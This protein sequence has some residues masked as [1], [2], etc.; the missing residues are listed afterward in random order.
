M[1]FGLI[2]K[3]I[4]ETWLVTLLLGLLIFL[5]HAVMAYAL[6]KF[7]EHFTD[8]I[9][10]LPF[11]REFIQALLGAEVGDD[12]GAELFVVLPWVHPIGLTVVWA[13]SIVLCTR[14]PAGEVDR[15]TIDV[16]LGLP[17]SRWTI[18]QSET[19]VWF[20]SVVALLMFALLG[21]ITGSLFID[22]VARP[23]AMKRL[24]VLPYFFSMISAVAAGAMLLSALSERRGRAIGIALG[25]VIASVLL[26][27]IAQFWDF[28]DH[29]SFLSVLT[30]YRPM[31]V[32]RDGTI[33]AIDLVVLW[34]VAITCWVAA[35]VIF[36][37]RDLKT[38]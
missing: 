14:V 24:L 34:S 3:A 19:L 27:Y 32:F 18:L 28:A 30:W 23:D 5:S 1:N 38:T 33:P 29:F 16:L 11:L 26:E 8:Q 25:I 12:F 13:H 21:N 6:P 37:R 20:G 4:H 35:G 9:M 10:T 2:R 22:P 7:S 15:G 36:S 31:E 17:I